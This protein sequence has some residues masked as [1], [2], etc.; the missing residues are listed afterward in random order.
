MICLFFGRIDDTI[1][2][3]LDFLTFDMYLVNSI[4]LLMSCCGIPSLPL[5]GDVFYG[6]FL[7]GYCL[8]L[9]TAEVGYRCYM[10]VY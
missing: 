2:C 6:W 5:K 10:V 3:F 4:V 8:S 9:E 7:Q 1:N